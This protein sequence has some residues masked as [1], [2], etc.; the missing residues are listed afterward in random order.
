MAPKI[1]MRLSNGNPSASQ[2]ASFNS[3]NVLPS[4]LSIP[5]SLKSSMIS[6]IHNVKP[7]CGGCGRH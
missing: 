7:G 6:R 2:I 4:P 1:Q 3:K 5:S